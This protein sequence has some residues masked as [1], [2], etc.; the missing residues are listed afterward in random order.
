MSRDTGDALDPTNGFRLPTRPYANA[1]PEHDVHT[2]EL[3]S[4]T[5]RKPCEERFAVHRHKDWARAF[6]P[7]GQV[8]LALIATGLLLL[9]VGFVWVAFML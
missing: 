9:I 6:D 8:F 5:S 3:N 7:H 4:G 1:V 2:R